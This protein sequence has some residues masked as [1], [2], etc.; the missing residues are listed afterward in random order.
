ML[1][2]WNNLEVFLANERPFDRRFSTRLSGGG[3]ED[4]CVEA[5]DCVEA[6]VCASSATGSSAERESVLASRPTDTV[7]LTW[8]FLDSPS[9]SHSSL[10]SG[11]A[12]AG[13][14]VGVDLLRNRPSLSARLVR[15]PTSW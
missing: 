4:R 15:V 12:G 7:A 10:S 3:A 13:S 11:V 9:T 6:D 5:D 14:G 1:L 8:P 2:R